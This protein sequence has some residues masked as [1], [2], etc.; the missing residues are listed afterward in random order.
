MYRYGDV[1]L[2]ERIVCTNC[3]SIDIRVVG[4]NEYK[5]NQC[6]NTFKVKTRKL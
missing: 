2:P 1:K 4:L 5:C 3:H 6:H